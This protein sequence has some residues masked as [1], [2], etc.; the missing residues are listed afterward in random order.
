MNFSNSE[1]IWGESQKYIPGGVNSPVR[2]FKNISM[3]PIAVKHAKKCFIE[4]ID[5]NRYLDFLNSWGPLILGHSHPKVINSIKKQAKVGTSYGTITENEYSFAKLIVDNVLPIDKIRFVNSGTEA[6]MTALRL[7]RGIT[8]RNKIIKFDGCYHGHADAMLVGSGSGLMTQFDT[9]SNSKGLPYSL[10]NDTIVLHLDDEKELEECF[11]KNQGQIAAVIIEPLPANSGLLP[12]RIEFLQK[13]RDITAQNDVLFILD[14]VITG[15]RLGF[16]G[17]AGKYKIEPDLVTYGKIIGGGMPI[18]A[19]AGKE[20]YIS[21]LAP[22]GD[23]YQAGTLS[24]NPIAI[25]AGYATLE[26]LLTENV[27]SHLEGL[28]NYLVGSF[29]EEIMPLFVDQ[30]IMISLIVE[31]SLFWLCIHKKEDPIPFRKAEMIWNG[32]AKIYNRIFMGMIEK[33]IYMAPSAYEIGFLSYPMQKKHIDHFI[34]ALKEI[35]KKI[36]LKSLG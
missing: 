5:S 10:M 36:D 15:F 19:I 9:T 11:Q 28:S 32:S 26:T 22:D 13:I 29:S 17:F 7:S 12:Q 31:E 3:H 2:A 33:K 4:D 30:D 27:Y 21:K 18:G 35:I 24:G 6:V 16:S 8:N 14:E 34:Y 1:R 25:S 23:I 20:N